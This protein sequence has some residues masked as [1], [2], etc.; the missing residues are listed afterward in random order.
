VGHVLTG[1]MVYPLFTPSH[2]D[3][4]IRAGKVSV[5]KRFVSHFTAQRLGNRLRCY[6]FHPETTAASFGVT[7][8]LTVAAANLSNLH[9]QSL[10]PGE[11]AP[12]SE[13]S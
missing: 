5:L 10:L 11:S 8:R 2:P 3:V 6:A 13:P 4:K 9:I 7:A 1:K 12:R